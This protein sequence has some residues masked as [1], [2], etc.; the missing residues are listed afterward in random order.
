MLEET[1]AIKT[2][3]QDLA[4]KGAKEEE[5]EETIPTGFRTETYKVIKFRGLEFE[6]RQDEFYDPLFD[7]LKEDEEIFFVNYH[8]DFW[9]ERNEIITE[10]ETAELYRGERN[11]QK[12]EREKGYW[13]FELSCLIHSG[14]WLKLSY[15]GF[16]SDPGGW[17]TSH[18][19]L[20]LVSKKI[21]KT[22]KKA[23]KLAESLV[24]YWNKLL[25]GE[26]Y[27]VIVR[28]GEKIIDEVQVV[29]EIEVLRFIS[30]YKM[31]N[32]VQAVERVAV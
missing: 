11:W 23:E 10:E 3:W 13:I 17:D 16:I 7:D 31:I 6:V 28:K 22:R 15:S 25:S 21:A 12:T 14:V 4:K 27:R 24:D 18:V 19:G 5:K 20:V 32:K 2:I 8:R 1:L 9:I 29:G 26:V 30:E